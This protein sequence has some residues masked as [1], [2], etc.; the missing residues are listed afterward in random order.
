MSTRAFYSS[1]RTPKCFHSRPLFCLTTAPLSGGVPRHYPLS[2]TAQIAVI[3][4]SS[5]DRCV[6]LLIDPV[7]PKR[8][9]AP[10]DQHGVAGL[11]H[12]SAIGACFPSYKYAMGA[13]L[14][15]YRYREV[16]NS[17]K[18]YG[19]IQPRGGG[20]DVFVH[21]SAVERAGLDAVLDFPIKP[22]MALACGLSSMV[23]L[24]SAS[25]NPSIALKSPPFRKPR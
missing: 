19:F 2:T 16:F 12:A 17:Q 3:D 18:G 9:A 10:D 6:R 24:K 23:S 13:D 11:D 7:V 8:A 14:D 1:I 21:I 20:K 22:L 15:A 25:A 5:I 4:P